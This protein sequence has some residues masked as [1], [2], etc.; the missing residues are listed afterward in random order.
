MRAASDSNTSCV[1]I[2]NI[3]QM[4]EAFIQSASRYFNH[5]HILGREARWDQTSNWNNGGAVLLNG[6]LQPPSHPASRT[7]SCSVSS[8]IAVKAADSLSLFQL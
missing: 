7:V 2:Y 3:C 1:I 4:M 6:K 5:I 8:V